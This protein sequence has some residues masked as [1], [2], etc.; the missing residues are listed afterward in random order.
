ML[1][2]YQRASCLNTRTHKCLWVAPQHITPHPRN[3]GL[4]PRARSGA[5]APGR[6]R[7]CCRLLDCRAC[8]TEGCRATWGQG[9]QQE[10]N[11]SLNQPTEAVGWDGL[12]VL[13]W[14]CM[15]APLLESWLTVLVITYT[16]INCFC[17]PFEEIRCVLCKEGWIKSNWTCVLRLWGSSARFLASVG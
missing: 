8:R 2:F 7:T 14:A 9:R 15:L 5:R 1:S 13:E 4:W 12:H 16:F 17:T 6:I 10:L 11:R 3:Q